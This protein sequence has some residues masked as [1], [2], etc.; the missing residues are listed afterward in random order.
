MIERAERCETCKFW[1]RKEYAAP[2]GETAEQREDRLLWQDRLSECRIRS[3][4][5]SFPHRFPD[6]WCGEWQ[7]AEQNYWNPLLLNKEQW[8]TGHDAIVQDAIQKQDSG[9]VKRYGRTQNISSEELDDIWFFIYDGDESEGFAG[10]LPIAAFKEH[11]D[12]IA[13]VKLQKD[14]PQKEQVR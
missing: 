5:H 6:D 3:V 7:A 4:P 8:K 14:G 12:A 2:E 11:A 13:F 1:Q 10:K 9:N